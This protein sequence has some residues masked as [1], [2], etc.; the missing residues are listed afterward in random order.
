[1]EGVQPSANDPSGRYT[2]I[3]IANFCLG[4]N[5]V[6]PTGGWAPSFGPLSVADYMKPSSVGYVTSAAYP[7]RA[8]RAKLLSEYEGFSSHTNAVSEIRDRLMKS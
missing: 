6:L 3:T 2:P 4:P 1:L 7:G 5:G 8:R